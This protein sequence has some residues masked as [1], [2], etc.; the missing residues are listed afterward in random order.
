[1]RDAFMKTKDEFEI[2]PA[3]PRGFRYFFSFSYLKL[4]A[5]N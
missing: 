1:M 2:D 3:C 4:D 5:R